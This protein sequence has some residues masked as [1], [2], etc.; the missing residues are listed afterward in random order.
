MEVLVVGNT[1]YVDDDFCA[2][3]FPGDH[4][5]VVAAQDAYRDE[6]SPHSSWKELLQHLD[7]AYE[8]DRM[9]YLSNY[10]TPHTDTVGDIELLRSV[11]R[12]CAGRRVQLLYVAGPASAEGASGAVGRTGKGI[13]ARAANDLCRYYAVREGVQ[14]KILRAPFLYTASAA[15]DDPFFVPL[16]DSCLTGSVALQGAEDAAFPLLCAEELAV[17]VRRIF[18]SWDASFETLDVADIFHRTS[19]EVGEALKALFS[20]LS[21]AYGDSAG[22]ALPVSDTVRVRYGWFQRYD[23]LR[24]LSTIQA[25]WDAGRA[26]K[27]NPLRAAID[28]IQMRTPPIKCLE[29]VAAWVLFEVLEHLFS[30]STQ[31]NVLDYRLLYVVLIGTLYG[32]DFGLVAALLASV[33]LA[34]SYFTQ[35]GYTFQGLFYEPSNWL[36]FIAYFVVGAVCGYVQLRNS[37]AI[38]AERDQNDLVRNRNTFLTQLYHDAIEDKRAYRRQIVGRH[39]SFGKIFAVTQELDVLNPRDIY[40]KCCELLGEILENDSV[41]I[42]HVSGGAFARLVAA[43]PAIA[44]DAA[45]S[46]TLEQLAPLLSDGGR[47]NLWV[48]RE[49]MPGLPMFGYTIERDGAPAVLIFV[50]RAAENQMTLYYQNLFRILC[51]LVESALGRAFDYEAV[52]QDKRCVDGTCVLKQ[53][54]FGQELAAEQALADGKMGSFLLLR[55]VP[56]ME[57]IGE[58]VGAIGSAIRESDAAGLIDGDVLYL[59]MR[60]AKACDLPIIRE[61]L[62]EKQIEVEPVDGEDIVALLQHISYT[63]DGEG[64]VPLDLAC[65]CCR[66]AADSCAGLPGAVDAHE[67][68]PAAG[69]RAHAAC[70]SAGAAVGPVAGGSAIGLQRGVWRGTE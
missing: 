39:D 15:L 18:D 43:S 48:N 59:L 13:I 56:G 7:Q 38:R 70:D 47:S 53:A 11:F 68:G 2:K 29:T 52:A 69:A 67:V 40:R 58:L 12:A 20:G 10:L 30:Q 24:D 14:A 33:G 3:A 34:A 5:Q 26:K 51:G 35:Y 17:L 46:L 32:L 41:A 57:P 63:G 64:G 23:L 22:Y 42:Y 54:A 9:V 19:G 37:E 6:S 55:V 49:L 16:F 44:E 8:F 45:R 1:A 4:V 60:Q 25:R 50:R 61:R 28:R 31:L 62:S 66:L 65:R 36:P 21:V 27:V